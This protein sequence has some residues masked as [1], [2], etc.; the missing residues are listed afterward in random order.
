SDQAKPS[1]ADLMKQGAAQYNNGQYEESLATLQQVDG[2]TLSD[3]DHNK[4]VDLLS[5]SESAANER[6]AARA[7][8]EMGEQARQSHRL[9][10]AKAHYVSA[11]NNPFADAGTKSKAQEQIAL[12]EADRKNAQTDANAVYN[13][14]VQDYNNKNYDAAKSGFQQ[15]VA[16]GYKAPLFKETPEQYLN[17]IGSNAGAAAQPANTQA[18]AVSAYNAAVDQYRKGDWH[19]ARANFN[20]ARDLGF[21]PGFLQTS[22][23][24]YLT[25]IDDGERAWMEQENARKQQAQ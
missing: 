14:A 20:K 1:N 6:K 21:K 22:P 9:V 25:K 3:Q 12:V 5:R 23:G 7:Q 24:E 16:S 17:D 15:L 18:Q 13:Q 10:E 8:F 19:N 2:K 11:M 4:L